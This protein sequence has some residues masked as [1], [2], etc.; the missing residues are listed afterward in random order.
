M[1]SSKDNLPCCKYVR[2][3]LI[4]GKT[5]EEIYE[6]WKKRGYEEGCGVNIKWEKHKTIWHCIVRN[7][8]MDLA[9]LLK[10]QYYYETECYDDNPPILMAIRSRNVKMVDLLINNGYNVGIRIGYNVGN[11]LM[12]TLFNG[13]PNEKEILEICRILIYSPNG[14][15][16]I[17]MKELSTG[18]TALHTAVMS[19]QPVVV[20]MLLENGVDI[21]AKD[22]GGWTPL[23]YAMIYSLEICELLLVRGADIHIAPNEPTLHAIPLQEIYQRFKKQLHTVISMLLSRGADPN[24]RTRRNRMPLLFEAVLKQDITLVEMLINGGAD[25]NI[26]LKNKD[27]ALHT[28]LSVDNN[29]YITHYLLERGADMNLQNKL[30]LTPLLLAVQNKPLTTIQLLLGYDKNFDVLTE[31]GQKIMSFAFQRKDPVIIKYLTRKYMKKL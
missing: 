21:N 2:N 9:A 12:L 23:R 29:D 22:D 6:G 15:Q 10:E 13:I 26:K 5:K 20:E 14:K 3:V 1:A 18:K 30:G 31:Y 7:N 8:R 19:H 17:N 16:L 24:A 25:I 4:E 27:T 28:S 11:I